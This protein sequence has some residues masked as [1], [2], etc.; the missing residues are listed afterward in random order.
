MIWSTFYEDY[1]TFFRFWK[2]YLKLLSVNQG[3]YSKINRQ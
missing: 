3:D 1:I 2:L